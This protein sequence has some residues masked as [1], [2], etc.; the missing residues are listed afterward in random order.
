MSDLPD[1]LPSDPAELRVFA[2]ALLDRCARL[3]RLLKLAKDAQFGRSSEKLDADQL[4]LILEDIDQAVA[5]LEAAEDRANPK[6]REKRAAERRANRGKLPEHLPRIIETL[7]PAA[8]CCPCCA[9]DLFEIGHDESQ[10][11]DVVPAQYRVIVTRR[12]KLA[13][14]ACHGVVLQHAAPERLIRGGLPTERLVAHVIDAK[15][16]WHLPLYRQTQ[17]LA[18]HGI[19]IDRSTLAFWVGYAAQEL[20]PCGIACASFYSPLRSSVS[21]R[22]RRRCWIPGAAGPK[23]ATS[24]RCRAMTGLGPGL[25]RPAWSMPMHQAAAPFMAC[26]CS[27]AIAASSTATAIR[28]TRMRETRADALSGTLAFCWSHL[29][30]QFVKIEREASPAPAPVAREALERIAQLYAVEKALRGRSDAGRRAGRQAHARPLA[31][32]LKQWFEAK[33]GH[34][35]Q[36]SETAKALRYALRHWDGLT[37]YLDDGRI[38]MDTNAVERA[39]RPIKLNAKNALFAGCDEGAENWALLASLIETCKLNGV[40]AEYWLADVLAKL[41]NGWPAARLDELLPW[42]S[43]YTMHA[44]D[45]RL[46][47]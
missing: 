32:A 26:D 17:M 27:K 6:T 29:R 12:P 16:H 24:G 8:T 45:P 37:L 14:R 25:I 28:L 36:K 9:G 11:L 38:E 18:T 3:E 15:Y 41:V 40:S 46:A 22:P 30:R 33:L 20:S 10:R 42:A 23:P 35:A 34:L 7:M 31:A 21:M 19:A 1:E 44:Q 5:A 39:M 4:Q 13:C 2:A 43:T 47:A